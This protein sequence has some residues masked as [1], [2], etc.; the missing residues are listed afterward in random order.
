MVQVDQ[1]VRY[2]GVGVCFL[3]YAIIPLSCLS[4]LD[5]TLYC[6]QT[7]GWIKMKLG[8]EVGLGPGH[9]VLE[10]DQFPHGKGHSSPLHF[11]ARVYRS[12]TVARLSN[13]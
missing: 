9:I 11:S 1:S 4:V 2:V 7:V 10:G 8:V 5:V 3:T 6:G 12:Q 13:C